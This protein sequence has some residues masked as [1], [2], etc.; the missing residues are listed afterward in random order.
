[1][2]WV[3]AI[4][5]A[6]TLVALP[7]AVLIGRGIRLAND[8]AAAPSWTDDVEQFLRAQAAARP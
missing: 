6:W 3:I 7:M 8:V 5:S 2:T 4:G 1:M